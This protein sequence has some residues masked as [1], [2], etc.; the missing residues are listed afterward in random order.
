VLG[1]GISKCGGHE[2]WEQTDKRAKAN[3]LNKI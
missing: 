2:E 1:F 3:K